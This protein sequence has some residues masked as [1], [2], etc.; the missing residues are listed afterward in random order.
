MGE[1]ASNCYL[2]LIPG[3]IDFEEICAGL[4]SKSITYMDVRNQSELQSDG[5][6]VGS[7]NL[8]CNIYY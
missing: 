6:I 5:Q 4:E 2:L 3:T 1:T 8:P 7:V